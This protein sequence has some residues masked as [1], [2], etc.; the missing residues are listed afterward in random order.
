MS[1]PLLEAEKLREKLLFGQ[2]FEFLKMY[3]LK[4]V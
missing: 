3:S 1:F 2:L 4:T